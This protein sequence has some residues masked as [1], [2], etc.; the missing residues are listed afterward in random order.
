LIL[1]PNSFHVLSI[2]IGI[3]PTNPGDPN[4]SG[5]PYLDFE[6]WASSEGETAY[7]PTNPTTSKLCQALTP[8][9]LLIK[10][11]IAVAYKLPPTP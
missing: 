8:L 10:E 11:E 2:E 1:P 3:Q 5:A 9:N 4:T 7:P 6:M